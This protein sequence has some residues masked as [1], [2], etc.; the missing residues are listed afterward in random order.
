MYV[1]MYVMYVLQDEYGQDRIAADIALQRHQGAAVPL[2]VVVVDNGAGDCDQLCLS[3]PVQASRGPLNASPGLSRPA[4]AP[5]L[6][7]S[8]LSLQEKG[9][10]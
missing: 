3:R 4:A 6:Q 5:P 8:Q 1:C 7:C 2:V 9:I 10:F